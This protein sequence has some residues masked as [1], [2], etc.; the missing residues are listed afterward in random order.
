MKQI[1][2]TKSEVF[3]STYDS[4]DTLLP[5]SE[6]YKNTENICVA[7]K[8]GD[9]LIKISPKNTCK[10]VWYDAMNEHREKLMHSAYWQMVGV[11]CREVNQ[12]I[13]MLEHDPI[14]WVWSDT[15]YGDPYYFGLI[16]Y[17][18]RGDIDS[19]N[20]FYSS[21]IRATKVFKIEE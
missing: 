1:N 15:E 20:K 2:T 5:V 16:Y 17:G 14:E 7:V 6:E 13:K 9:I 18:A 21:S 10:C 4:S 8:F 3:L 12:A 19:L 11:V